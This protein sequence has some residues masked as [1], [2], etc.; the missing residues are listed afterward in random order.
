M[1]RLLVLPGDGVGPE[2]TAEALRVLDWFARHRGL[3]LDVAERGFGMRNWREH[4][5]LMPDET[6]AR[7]TEADAILFGATGSLDQQAVIAP[8]ERRKG[9]LL[10]MRKALDLFCNLRPVRV[11]DAC[12]KRALS[13]RAWCAAPTSS[14]CASFRP[15]C[16][17]A[18]RAG[19]RRCRT[20]PAAAST[21]T[22]T[23]KRRSSASCAT[24]SAWRAPAAA[25][26]PAWTRPT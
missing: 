10:R 20:A 6:W 14:S 18:R 19:W 12:W 26:S 8:E 2:V 17:S 5:T 9:S 7:I 22:A 3:A 13:S 25:T 1:I 4:G 21:P 16:I 24:P 23:R 11:P 15:G